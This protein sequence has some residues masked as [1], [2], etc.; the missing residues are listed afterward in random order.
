MLAEMEEVIALNK[1]IQ[2]LRDLTNYPLPE[3]SVAGNSSPGDR[4][5]TSCSPFFVDLFT[6]LLLLHKYINNRLGVYLFYV[7]D[8]KKRFRVTGYNDSL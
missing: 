4:R 3:H 5:F 8:R 7:Y 2:S 1:E 6:C